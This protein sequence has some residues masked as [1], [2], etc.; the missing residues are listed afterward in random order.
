M[1][2]QITKGARSNPTLADG[3]FTPDSWYERLFAIFAMMVGAQVFGYIIGSTTSVI[4]NLDASNAQLQMRLNTL[5]EYMR[6]RRLPRDLQVCIRK[7]FRYLWSRRTVFSNE[8]EI[9]QDLSVP[10]RTRLLRFMHR[11]VLEQMPLFDVCN[12][13]GFIDIIVRAMKPLFC[14][15]EDCIVIEGEQGAEMYFLTKGRVEV[16]HTGSREEGHIKVAELQPGAFFGEIALLDQSIPGVPKNRRLATVRAVEF[17][18]LRSVHKEHVIQCFEEFPEVQQSM[19]ETVN[20]RIEEL[21]AI[22]RDDAVSISAVSISSSPTTTRPANSANN[23]LFIS[24]AERAHKKG[25]LSAALNTVKALRDLGHQASFLGPRAGSPVDPPGDED[26]ANEQ[27]DGDDDGASDDGETRLKEVDDMLS[28]LEAKIDG[29]VA[30]PA[31][32]LAIR[33]LK[34]AVREPAL[35]RAA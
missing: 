21:I 7:Y 25:N 17:C 34:L 29:P 22:N 30:A 3:D 23:S 27:P 5:N 33:A 32:Q 18:E 13:P 11:D 10:L 12:D 8:E 9:L 4:A 19:T 1:P 6:D 24:N 20:R 14:S 31:L 15:K 2:L 28:E 35:H 26:E 16:L